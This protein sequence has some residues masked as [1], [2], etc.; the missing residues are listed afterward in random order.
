MPGA[1]VTVEHGPGGR[2][3]CARGPGE[4][5][6]SHG[7]ALDR[8]RRARRERR[9]SR[10][11]R[12]QARPASSA[13]STA[14]RAASTRASASRP[15]LSS[16]STPR[17]GSARR[18]AG[19][20]PCRTLSPPPQLLLAW[21]SSSASSTSRAEA[22]PR[23]PRD[24]C[25]RRSGASWSAQRSPLDALPGSLGHAGDRRDRVDGPQ[26][27]LIEDQVTYPI[28]TTFL[29]APKVKTVR[30]FTMFG[31]SFVYVIFEDGTDLYWARSR[32]V[33]YLSKVQDK[34]PAR[35]HAADR[36]RRDRASA[37][38]SSTRSSTT[39]GQARPAG[40]ARRSRTGTFATGCRA[41]L[42]SPRSRASAASRSSTRSRSIPS[43]LKASQRL[44]RADRR[45]HARAN[46]RRRRA[47]ASRWRSTSTRSAAA[48]TSQRQGGPRAGRRR[49]RRARDADPHRATSPTSPIGGNIRRGLAELDGE[50]EV[51]GGIVVMRSGEN[52]LDVIER[53]K[54]KLE[55]VEALD[56]PQGVKV[57]PIYDRSQLITRLGQDA[58]RRTSLQILGDRRRSSIVR[59]P[60]PLPLGARRRDHA[61]GRDGASTFIPFYYLGHHRSTSCRSPGII[62][63]LGDMVDSA[64]VLVE[65]A[66]KKIE[67]AEREGE[68]STARSSSST[69]RASSGLR[70]FGSLLVLTIA[71]L[72]V[73]ALEGRRAGS[74]G[75]SRSRR[76]SRWRS[77]R[78]F[79][80]T[81]VPALMVTFLRGRIRPEAKNPI[82]R[83]CIAAYR[84]LLRFCLRARYVVIAAARARSSARPLVPFSRLGSEFMPPLYEGDLLYMPITVPGISIEEAKRLAHLA[85]PADPRGPRGRAR[86]RQGRTRRDARSTR[87]RSRCSRPSCVLKPQERVARRD[88]HGEAHR[89]AR[90]EARE[91]PGVQG[92][93]TMPIKARIDMLSTGIRTPIGIKVF[94]PDLEEIATINDQLERSLRDVPGHAQRLRR[95]RAR[96]LLPR[97]SCRTARRSRA[98]ASRVRTCSTSSR[99]AIGG[100]D[101]DTT[102]EGRERYRDQ[103]PLS[104]RAPRQ[105]RGAP[106]VLVPISPLDPD[107]ASRRA[108]RSWRCRARAVM[109]ARRRRGAAMGGSAG[110]GGPS[111]SVLAG[112]AG[113]GGAGMGGGGA[114]G[115]GEGGGAAGSRGATPSAA[116]V[117]LGQLATHRDR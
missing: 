101:V 48:A 76:R 49:D 18:A 20:R 47:R 11:A 67:E 81:L 102:I 88:D 2:A 113:G 77:R 106:R 109:A 65:N 100:M 108:W 43:R 61:A 105:P 71:F 111:P 99:A 56:C 30:G 64:V 97:L 104:A 10:A 26:P 80:I 83:F 44:G 82:N 17:A 62:I 4:C 52:A 91:L 107:A 31:M 8:L 59:L 114:M 98:T 50:G 25:A 84:P 93:W 42:A 60:V 6:D 116:F 58:R 21:D 51:V 69:R 32:V 63:A 73:F 41:S 45:G 15:A 57:V 13:T 38:S 5:R 55:E 87:R 12:G 54:A 94:G 72:P 75:R 117:P 14:S 70:I 92:A 16:C 39:S 37:G 7:H 112:I 22:L 103:R 86:L 3:A 79:A 24:R 115:G 28:T 40:A 89:R 85:G 46:A 1:F 29:G 78:C 36:A 96:R 95:A 23:L 110:M 27:D 33:E 9:A 66:H 53:V 74:S 19:W 35:R 34:L 68:P 90:C